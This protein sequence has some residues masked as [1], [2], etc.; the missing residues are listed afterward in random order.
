MSLLSLGSLAVPAR[1]LEPASS[2]PT[3]FVSLGSVALFNAAGASPYAYELW[4][5]DGTEAG[6]WQ[7]THL[8]PEPYCT[9]EPRPFALTSRHY[10]FHSRDEGLHLNLWATDGTPAG[11]FQLTAPPAYAWDASELRV[12]VGDVLYFYRTEGD[13]G[14]IWRSD[15]TPAGTWQVTDHGGGPMVAFQGS[16]YFFGGSALWKTDGTPAG[17]VRVAP[18]P[19]RYIPIELHVAGN[20]LVFLVY[21][22]SDRH[23]LWSSDGTAEGTLELGGILR[24][25]GLA[26]FVDFSVQD[27]RLYFVVDDGRNGQELWVT[28][29]TQQNT[30]ALT[31]LRRKEAFYSDAQQDYLYLPR[32]AAG[33]FFVFAVDDG[34]HGIEPWVTDGTVKGTHLLKD[35]CPGPCGSATRVWNR[36]LPGLAFMTVTRG[37]RGNELWVTDGTE[38]GTRLVRDICPG[39]CGSHPYE[40]FVV[41][42]R[43]LFVAN[44]GVD[45]Y[46][47]WAT[48]GT[49]ANTTRI[50]DFEPTL[51]WGFP[52]YEDFP[53]TVAGG[54]LLFRAPGPEGYELWRTDGTP[55][56]TRLVS[57]IAKGDGSP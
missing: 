27:G 40:P 35:L 32:F 52:G 3:A 38:S 57:D 17:T 8:C 33:S 21:T 43:L 23:Q 54:Q 25:P 53:G 18:L 31:R 34:P 47:L 4:R 44:D 10:F 1:G 30:R 24:R 14:G 26:W 2:D 48:D 12:S 11:T 7:V 50:S 55:A 49:E 46:E 37:S 20:R 39:S 51:P 45:G 36:T 19:A 28:D 29:G 6:T 22:P 13:S 9:S 41:K 15:G 42:N 16:I 56:G 5:S